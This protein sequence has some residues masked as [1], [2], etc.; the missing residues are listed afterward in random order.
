M[1]RLQKVHAFRDIPGNTKPK[2]PRQRFA[3][4][5]SPPSSVRK[6]P[7]SINSETK[8]ILPRVR[9][10]KKKTYPPVPGVREELDL[11]VAKYQTASAK[12]CSTVATAPLPPEPGVPPLPAPLPAA[13]AAFDALPAICPPPPPP[14][15]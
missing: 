13:A 15:P 4:C 3:R 2:G 7:P 9:R 6:S 5:T 12:S 14:P 1:L 10:P 8:N 11:I